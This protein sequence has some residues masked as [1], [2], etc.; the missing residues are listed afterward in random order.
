MARLALNPSQLRQGRLWR[1]RL[2]SCQQFNE[3][4][5]TVGNIVGGTRQPVLLILDATERAGYKAKGGCL[6]AKCRWRMPPLAQP[7][8]G[9]RQDRNLTMPKPPVETMTRPQATTNPGTPIA[10]MRAEALTMASSMPALF[11]TR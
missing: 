3:L 5:G 8:R 2:A 7:Y 1:D 11:I 9:S 10:P 4:V 6:F